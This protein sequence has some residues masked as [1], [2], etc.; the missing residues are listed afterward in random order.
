MPAHA[1]AAPCIHRPSE[2]STVLYRNQAGNIHSRLDKRSFE[3]GHDRLLPRRTASSGRT[4]DQHTAA[5]YGIGVDIA[6]ED[7]AQAGGPAGTA[8]DD[9]VQAYAVDVRLSSL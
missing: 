9:D 7:D 5:Y 2:T 1:A 3:T 4:A 8:A 6:S